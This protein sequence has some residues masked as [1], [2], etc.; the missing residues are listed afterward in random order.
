LQPIGTAIHEYVAPKEIFSEYA[1]FASSTWLDHA[2]RY[3]ETMS[4]WF[5]LGPAS[6]VI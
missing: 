1:Y 5:G 3:V 4:E 2:R 6:P